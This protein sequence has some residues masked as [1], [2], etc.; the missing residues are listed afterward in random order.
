MAKKKDE[1]PTTLDVEISTGETITVG[2]LDRKGY[3]TIKQPII[4]RMAAR[5]AEALSDLS[6]IHIPEPTR[7]HANPY[8]VFRL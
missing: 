7:R 5:A 6:L 1:R 4:D 2:M 3:K 8:A